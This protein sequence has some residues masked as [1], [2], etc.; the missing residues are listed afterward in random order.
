LHV[1][2]ASS[3][4]KKK[5]LRRAM[6]APSQLA[7]MKTRLPSASVEG[8]APLD[9]QEEQTAE[10]EENIDQYAEWAAAVPEDDLLQYAEGQ[11]ED[12]WA[13]AARARLGIAEPPK[14]EKP[15]LSDF[16]V[17]KI[18]GRGAFATVYKVTQNS[19]SDIYAMKV[20]EIEKLRKMKALDRVID[21]EKPVLEQ[22]HHP[23]VIELIG[24]YISTN[25]VYL[26]MEYCPAGDLKTLL[27]TT[28]GR[29]TEHQAR[30]YTAELITA[31][32]CLHD[33]G[34]VYR[35]L[36]PENVLL[37]GVGHIRLT[38]FGLVKREVEEV[39]VGAMSF[40]G[41]P[42]YL[43]PEM[44]TQQG[45]GHA[46]DWW[47]LGIMLF[48]M[49]TGDTP[50]QGR[51]GTL[52]S[53]YTEIQEYKVPQLSQAVRCSQLAEQVVE[54]LLVKDPAQRLSGADLRTHPWFAAHN[55]ALA[56]PADWEMLLR[57]EISPPYVPPTEE[58]AASPAQEGRTCATS[59][60]EKEKSQVVEEKRQGDC[61]VQ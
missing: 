45:H 3:S 54:G 41:T 22:I 38:D 47:G 27:H 31:L 56:T 61:S 10:Q 28:L 51:S 13:Q 19:T 44:I 6:S 2:P 9:E 40:L 33:Q 53:L 60:P 48:E 55:P 21:R 36:K 18:L 42:L 35:D 25:R 24:A 8:M 23:F 14:K 17:S 50:F 5:G 15:P 4:P 20:M 26:V 32:E 29:F 30:F 52:Q 43:S 34:V 16:A 57:K 12:P 46:T 37:D 1:L 39:D 11:P 7:A 59:S 58:E 49:L